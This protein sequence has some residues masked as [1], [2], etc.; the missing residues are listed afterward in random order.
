MTCICSVRTCIILSV[1]IASAK[2]SI[3]YTVCWRMLLQLRETCVYSQSKFQ[4]K[5]SNSL[6]QEK[7]WPFKTRTNNDKEDCLELRWQITKA[8]HMSI[9]IW[10]IDVIRLRPN[11]R[12][13]KPKKPQV[14]MTSSAHQVKL[15]LVNSNLTQFYNSEKQKILNLALIY[16]DNTGHC[17]CTSNNIVIKKWIFISLRIKEQ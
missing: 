13:Y 12:G 7:I 15:L 14:M 2:T 3:V 4:Q 17:K 11:T 5:K 9:L 8:Y 10:R 1:Y 16:Q 6:V